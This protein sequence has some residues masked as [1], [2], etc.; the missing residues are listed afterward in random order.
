MRYGKSPVKFDQKVFK[1]AN[2]PINR[3]VALGHPSGN[4]AVLHTVFLSKSLLKAEAKAEAP[5]IINSYCN[6][7]WIYSHNVL[8]GLLFMTKAEL[9]TVSPFKLAVMSHE[10]E[11]FKPSFDFEPQG[12]LTLQSTDSSLMFI[13]NATSPLRVK[14]DV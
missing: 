12:I 5:K 3:F 7:S 1:L 10:P 14:V 11:N 8:C 9:T 6:Y 4:R 2:I 13:T